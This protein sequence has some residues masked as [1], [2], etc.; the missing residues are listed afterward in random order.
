MDITPVLEEW[1]YEPDKI[2]VRK[3]V[4][5]DGL[6]RIQMRLDLGLL[7]MGSTGRPDGRRPHG[8]ESLLEYFEHRREQH[9]RARG[10]KADFELSCEDCAELRN[11]A[12]QY[13]YRYLS[14]LH[15]EDFHGVARD[16]ARNLR[17][18]DLIH[19]HAENE[20]DRLALERYRPY[21]LMMNARARAKIALLENQPVESLRIIEETLDKI[22]GFL[23]KHDREEYF[24]E[25][26]EVLFL[27]QLAQEI[28]VSIPRDP[29]EDL[30]KRM[31]RAVQEED[32][33]LAAKI[34]DK[35]RRLEGHL[36]QQPET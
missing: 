17:V 35:I 28:R 10:S 16:T 2:T 11:E 3:I 12:I 23:R 1:P 8:F 34:R 21:V 36:S 32:Y 31:H 18:F 25:S 7:Q 15:L 26:G 9:R 20:E 13:Y 6:E 33:E 5:N 24:D 22:R 27:R 14:L 19:E 29:R 4:G 30:R